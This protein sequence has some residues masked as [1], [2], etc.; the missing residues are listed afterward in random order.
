MIFIPRHAQRGELPTDYSFTNP[1]FETGDLTGWQW[2][3]PNGLNV[4]GAD[5]PSVM[6][7]EPGVITGVHGGTLCCRGGRLAW[8]Y[9]FQEYSTP[10]NYDAVIDSGQCRIRNVECW[11]N[12]Y[13]A[14]TDEGTIQVEYYDESDAFIIAHQSG[15]LSP[16]DVWTKRTFLNFLPVG[17]R[18]FRVGV[19]SLRNMGTNNNNYWDDF[20][21]FTLYDER[22]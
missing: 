4:A 20:A 3:D 11:H 10:I 15:W 13:A 22:F 16:D 14:Q 9:L 8:S 17:T 12:T 18:K 19:Y 6:A 1:G 5:A 7:G 21:G 2:Q